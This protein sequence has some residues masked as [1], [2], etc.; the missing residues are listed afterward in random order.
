[1][2]NTESK[3]EFVMLYVPKDMLIEAGIRKEDVLEIYADEDSIVIRRGEDFTGYIC[4]IKCGNCPLS[5]TDCCDNKN[6]ET[7]KG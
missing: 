6:K 4:D 1:M 7:E 2:I 3:M 5:C